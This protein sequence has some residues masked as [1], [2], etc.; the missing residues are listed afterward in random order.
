MKLD[1]RG[2]F[3][4]KGRKYI[5][6][7]E[8]VINCRR[9]SVVEAGRDWITI[10]SDVTGVDKTYFAR[11]G[12]TLII[13]DRFLD[14]PDYPCDKRLMGFQRKKGYVPYPFTLR[15]GV[16]KAPPG[17]KVIVKRKSIAYRPSDELRIFSGGSYE[18]LTFRKDIERILR[19]SCPEGLV[20]S[21][22][23]GFD[24]LLLT[25]V[26]RRHIRHIVH[27]RTEGVSAPQDLKD[28]PW[29]VVG[30]DAVFTDVERKAYFDAVDEPNCD[31]SGFAEFLMVRSVYAKTKLPIMNGQAADALFM[32]GR[33]Y[34]R[35][36]LSPKLL[37]LQ[38]NEQGNGVIEKLSRYLIDTKSRFES[39]YIPKLELHK[40]YLIEFDRVYRCYEQGI[41]NDSVSMFSAV[42]FILY[43]S[44]HGVEKIKTASRATGARYYLPFMTPDMI[45]L[46]FC[47]PARQKIG[48]GV[49]KRILR[50]A[51]P[52]LKGY[53]SGAFSPHE[54]RKRLMGS[55]GRYED[56]FLDEWLK[57]NS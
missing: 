23:G 29:T 7:D 14:F 16:Y 35:E 6:K 32:N 56:H 31:A 15:K 53:A 52:E 5:S 42:T 21:Y 9:G 51:Y 37:R 30:S 48:V 41:R 47:V 20:S 55:T 19:A 57:R 28:I 45:R 25:H 27:F 2:G 38:P 13:S 11:K 33:Q 1:A 3:R 40:D 8:S 10:C 54:L 12:A 22:S 17:L 24:S 26:L 46:A 34:L 18:R 4:K 39:F 49:G 43:Y 36:L 44:L 50:N